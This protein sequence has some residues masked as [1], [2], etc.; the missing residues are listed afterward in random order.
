MTRTIITSLLLSGLVILQARG[1]A[2]CIIQ[3]TIKDL[4]PGQWVYCREQGGANRFDSVKTVA[5]GF[6]FELNIPEGQG[7]GYMFSIGRDNLTQNSYLFAYLMKGRLVINGNGPLFK[8]VDF[9][10]SPFAVELND[11]NGFVRSQLDL[12]GWPAFREKIQ[13][14]YQTQDTAAINALYPEMRHWYTVRRALTLQWI[15][16]H[17]SSPVSAWE[18]DAYFNGLMDMGMMQKILYSLEPEARENVPARTLAYRIKMDSVLG[19]G[20]V[21]PVFSQ[22]DTLGKM[23]SLADFRGKYVLLDFWASWCGPC[24]AENPNVIAAFNK[25]KDRNYTVLGVSLDGPTGKQKW[26]DAI[27]SDHLTWTQV[28]DLKGWGNAAAKL[29]DINGIPANFLLDP[30]GKILAKGLRG[31]D[32]DMKLEEVLGVEAQ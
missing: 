10:G 23:V 28:C 1:Q 30:Q 24:R 5:G 17:P 25:Y 18:L 31:D 2:N 9:S 27:H 22:Q 4:A 13:K 6:T 8:D 21:A 16:G 12:S 20:R 15:K 32:L 14:T 3:A 29:Y 26:L 11:Y 19:I 7:D